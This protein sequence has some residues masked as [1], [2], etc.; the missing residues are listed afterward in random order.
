MKKWILI[1]LT[2][3]LV[4]PIII[5]AAVPSITLN[6]PADETV[7]SF[8]DT[9]VSVILTATVTDGDSD[10]M[11]VDIFGDNSTTPSTESLLFKEC[12]VASGTEINYNWTSPV[13]N[14]I[15]ANTNGLIISYHFDNRSEFGEND[16]LIYDFSGNGRNGTSS[17]PKPNKTGK[18]GGSYQFDGNAVGISVGTAE[19]WAGQNLT[20]SAWV[21]ANKFDDGTNKDKI[22]A[23]RLNSGTL[24]NF[25]LGVEYATGKV[26]YEAFDACD[27]SSIDLKTERILSNNTWYHLTW[28]LEHGVERRIYINGILS[29]NS[30]SGVTLP[31]C[32]ITTFIGQNGR[33]SLLNTAWNGL[34]DETN[35][36]N[37]TLSPDEILD[38]YRLRNDTYYWYVNASDGTDKIQS[39]TRK[40]YINPGVQ[41]L[42]LQPGSEG[43]DSYLRSNA[44]DTNFGTDTSLKLKDASGGHRRPI[45]EFNLSTLPADAV[46]INSTLEL[47]LQTQPG[48][49]FDTIVNRIT[50][51]WTETGVTWNSRNGVNDWSSAGGSISTPAI[52]TNV[53]FSSSGFKAL[54]VT[55]LITYWH[56]GTYNNSGMLITGGIT[57]VAV[58]LSS[59][60]Y[61]AD[62]SQRPKLTIYY[63]FGV[64]PPDTT[65][66]V[67]S[68]IDC[69]SNPDGDTTEP[70][71]CTGDM[72]PTFEF[73]TDENA[74]CD[75]SDS[76]TANW[77]DC[78]TTGATSHSCTISYKNMLKIQTDFVYLN[79]TDS[80]GNS[81]Y[82]ELETFIGDFPWIVDGTIILNEA[83]IVVKACT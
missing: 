46:I 12:N 66:P 52:V 76:N 80:S 43:K 48:G 8:N 72:T 7:F 29:A 40:F 75:I 10:L 27:G 18:L 36:Y 54:N 73:N 64:T 17:E 42:V 77:I 1:I 67:L 5:Y 11:C 2:I 44:A 60:D 65:P 23:G 14:S 37:R 82:D 9:N 39:E 70:Y 20:I 68:N 56:N 26:I 51:N 32:S 57:G 78:D 35:I 62:I 71:N 34:I 49:S 24:K 25:Q 63:K 30:S 6:A 59:S 81:A 58:D 38:L 79:C 47:Y 3:S 74:N 16:T 61:T 22:V 41:V 55:D 53:D 19:D 33:S 21:Y 31:S 50:E 83:A 4:I 13:V 69:T 28:T 15:Y 45:L